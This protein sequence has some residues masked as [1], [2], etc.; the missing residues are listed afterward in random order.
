MLTKS[1]PVTDRLIILF[2]SFALAAGLVIGMLVS[3]VPS[4][5]LVF[6]AIVALGVVTATFASADL[7]LLALVM[8]TYTRFS[9]VMIKHHNFPS[10]AQP[11]IL[12]LGVAILVRWAVNGQTPKGW[13]RSLTLVVLYGLVGLISLLFAANFERANI[14]MQDYA[15][16]AI[17]AVLVTVLLQRAAT[18]RRVVWGLLATGIFMG[19]ISVY[20]Q[21]TR[22][23][24]NNF[25]GFGEAPFQNI[26]GA[27]NDYRVA[28]PIGDPNF[29]ALILVVLVPLALDRVWRE[30]D[31]RMR[32]LAGWAFAVT[33]L[34]IVFSFSRGGFAALV[35]VLAVMLLSHPPRPQV[36]LLTLALAIPLFQFVPERY[37]DRIASIPSLLP[38][39]GGDPRSEVSL[40]GRTSEAR[41]AWQVFMDRP[42]LGVGLDNYRVYYQE[43][44]RQIGLDPRREERTPHDLYLEIASQTGIVG[45]LAFGFL[46]WVMFRGIFKARRV[47]REL[48]LH[49]YT[50]ITTAFAVGAL[51]YLMGSLF[52][53][54][55]YP[56]YFW[57]LFG[58]AMA[59]PQVA[60]NEREALAESVETATGEVP[61]GA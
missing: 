45:L 5:T 59:L 26:V 16:D 60:Q 52:L 30:K 48:S 38:F 18:L 36:V 12:L 31:A 10:T 40:R 19:T 11:F 61:V 37:I 39:V 51:G 27:A 54:G 6:G 9:D 3:S 7:G 46:L 21:L 20:Q 49:D 42:I 58:I 2:G 13:Q 55:A 24:K 43:Y 29:Y 15:K 41:V 33:T 50:G 1:S 14:A 44:S 56:R 32:V 53:H 28:G 57:L 17:I 34:S 8:L 22:S 47:F 25:G 35:I 23:F 4:P